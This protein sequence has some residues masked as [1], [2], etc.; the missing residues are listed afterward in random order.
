MSTSSIR[1]FHYQ[2]GSSDKIW[3][4]C[5]TKNHAST[6]KVWFGKRGKPLVSRDVPAHQSPD[7]RVLDKVRKGYVELFDMTVDPE[8]CQLVELLTP[9]PKE[10]PTGGLWYRITPSRLSELQDRIDQIENNLEKESPADVSILRS[11][12]LYEDIKQG[13]LSGG[14]EIGEGPLGVLLLFSLRRFGNSLVLP[15]EE[16]PPVSIADDYNGLLPDRFNDLGDY[17]TDTFKAYMI[18]KGHVSDTEIK[19]LGNSHVL[20]VARKNSCEHYAS[21]KAIKPLAI[22]MGC[23]DAPIDLAAIRPDQQSAFF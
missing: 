7:S 6:H 4:I 1:V 12:P 23:I 22:A 15:F 18:L 20:D 16:G 14:H 2:E 8:S 13:K 10:L 17:I 19:L 9:T 21:V 5:T 11:L 3:A